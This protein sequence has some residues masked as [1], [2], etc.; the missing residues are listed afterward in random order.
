MQEKT[1]NINEKI[2]IISF[3]E[4]EEILKKHFSCD[5]I[6]YIPA[7]NEFIIAH[8]TDPKEIKEINKKVFPNMEFV[9]TKRM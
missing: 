3:E 8:D 2:I 4:A 5:K 1:I 6:Y 7:R 9:L